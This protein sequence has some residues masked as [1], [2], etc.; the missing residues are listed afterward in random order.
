MAAIYKTSRGYG[1]DWRDEFGRRQRRF[2]GSIEAAQAVRAKL[3]ESTAIARAA[4]R[5]LA[6]C[7]LTRH[8]ASEAM[9]ANQTLAENTRTRLKETL[10]RAGELLGNPKATEVTPLLLARWQQTRQPQVAQNTFSTE[11]RAAL[12]EHTHSLTADA[13]I[14][15]IAARALRPQSAADFM[16]SLCQRAQVRCRYHDLRH[17]FALR[18]ADT[19]AP[20]HAIRALLGHGLLGGVALQP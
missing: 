19:G 16:R 9:L 2:V 18:L 13:L 15:N 3:E 7:D 14:S 10:R 5:N 4:F 11:A 6:A 1:V 12:K 20:F 8:E 17:T